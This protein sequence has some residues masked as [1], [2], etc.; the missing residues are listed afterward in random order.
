M[1]LSFTIPRPVSS[2]AGK[3]GLNLI[4]FQDAMRANLFLRKSLKKIH[5]AVN[6]P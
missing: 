4:G 1:A 6:R 3:H 5:P 2:F